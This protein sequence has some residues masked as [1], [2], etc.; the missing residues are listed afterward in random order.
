MQTHATLVAILGGRPQLVTF[1]LDKLLA[2]GEPIDQVVVLYLA[3]YPRSKV[4][5]QRLVEAFTG[6][7]YAGRPCRFRGV[8]IRAG[9][10]N[11]LDIRTPQEAEIVRQNVHFLLGELKEQGHI[12]HLGLSGGRRLISFTALAAA[13]QYLTPADHIWHLNVT[14]E[15]GDTDP[16]DALLH[17]PEDSEVYL[18]PVPFVPWAA[19]FPGLVP[20]LTPSREG[21]PDPI[22][23]WLSSDDRACCV[24]AWR[25]LTIRQREV[26][27]ALAEGLPRKEIAQ[28]LGISASTVDSHRN[29]ILSQC[30]QVWFERQGKEVSLQYIKRCFASF[31]PVAK[32]WNP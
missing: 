7:H 18:L 25:M 11:L 30:S 3:Y 8:P 17:A 24:A 2:H 26:L 27:E 23:P 31:I 6:D 13:M 19:Y 5:Y 22:M 15:L 1:M 29:N 14:P 16:E 9:K 20:L 10:D 12:I 32:L 4:A 21:L 28:R